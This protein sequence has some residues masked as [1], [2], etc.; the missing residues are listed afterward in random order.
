MF[1]SLPGH[2]LAQIRAKADVIAVCRFL[3]SRVIVIDGVGG[4]PADALT[5]GSVTNSANHCDRRSSRE[6]MSTLLKQWLTALPPSRRNLLAWT[7]VI[8]VRRGPFQE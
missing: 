8:H 4:N 3:A 1:A 5:C 2:V 6:A 7:A